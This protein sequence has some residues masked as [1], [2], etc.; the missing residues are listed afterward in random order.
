[1]YAVIITGGKQYKVEEGGTL[2]VEKLDAE[3]EAAM[4]SQRGQAEAEAIAA[5]G[6]A[7]AEAIAAKAEAQADA[8]KLLT[9]SLSE[10]I[11]EYEKI[12]KWDGKLPTVTGGAALVDIGTGTAGAS[13]GE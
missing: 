12:Q 9:Q 7:E 6:Q 5:R 4:I 10:L 2:F 8:N 3:A 11:V 1:M 13:A